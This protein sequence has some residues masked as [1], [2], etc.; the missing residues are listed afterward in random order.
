MQTFSNTIE[1]FK[2]TNTSADVFGSKNLCGGFCRFKGVCGLF[3]CLLCFNWFCLCPGK[4]F[5]CP[6]RF[7]DLKTLPNRSYSN[8]RRANVHRTLATV[9]SAEP[10]CTES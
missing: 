2:T 6:E 8:I 5:A 1:T 4:V 9:T 10:M 7:L 3:M